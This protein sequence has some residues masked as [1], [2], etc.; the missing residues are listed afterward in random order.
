MSLG[1]HDSFL[2]CLFP[3]HI[4]TNEEFFVYWEKRFKS[5]LMQGWLAEDTQMN[6]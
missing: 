6:K 5:F 4:H 2:F 1:R 3:S